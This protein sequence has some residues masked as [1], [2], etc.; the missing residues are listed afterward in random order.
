MKKCDRLV[1]L[2]LSAVLAGALG[3]GLLA[4]LAIGCGM[5][6]ERKPAASA[7]I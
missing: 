3:V 5:A 4:P 1:V 2:S 7:E 6:G